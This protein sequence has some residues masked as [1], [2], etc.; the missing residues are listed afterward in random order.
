MLAES[1]AES[2]QAAVQIA[3]SAQNLHEL[4]QKLRLLVER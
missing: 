4:G 1:I 3:A 2:A